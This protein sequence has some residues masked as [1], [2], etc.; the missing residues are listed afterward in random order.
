[1][2]AFQSARLTPLFRVKKH[3]MNPNAIELICNLSGEKEETK[4][5]VLFENGH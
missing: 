1:M 5:P 2:C 3:E 4:T